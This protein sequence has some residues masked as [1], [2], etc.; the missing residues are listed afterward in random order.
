MIS[1]IIPTYKAPEALD[2]C[3][4]SAIN[5]QQNKNQLIVVVDGFVDKTYQKAKK[6]KHPKVKVR[7]YKENK[8]KGFYAPLKKVR[9]F[10]YP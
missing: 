10:T 3:L 5:G 8:G 7:G 6:V 2:L 1:V 4:E 9:F